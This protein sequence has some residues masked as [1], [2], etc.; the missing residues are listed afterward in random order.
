MSKIQTIIRSLRNG[1]RLVRPLAAA[2]VPDVVRPMRLYSSQ[3][4]KAPDSIP[5]IETRAP[6][7]SSE[8]EKEDQQ[9]E[10]DVKARIL[11]KAL[12]FVGA[13]GWSVEALGAGAEAAGYPGVSHGLFPNGGADLVHYFN[14]KCNEDLVS[15]MKSWPKEDLTESKVPTKFVENAIVTR[16]QMLEPY[17]AS[18]PKAM[19]I[20]A[21]PSNV[22]NCLATLLSLVDDICYHSG[23]RSVDFNWYIRR[24]GLAGIYKAAELFYLTDSS[25]GN[26]GTRAFVAAR[27]RDAQLIQTAMNM[28][29]VSVAP[30]TLTAA[31]VT[32]KN[33]LGINT[34]K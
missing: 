34:L 3:G 12:G 20:Q 31:F 33:I 32:A 18:W 14:V 28:N 15:Q 11:E 1:H 24:V 2:S 25:A 6:G 29:P 10:E 16:L 19:A 27:I 7:A 17:K 21:L 30:Q 4:G 5:S 26:S 9:Y 22:P 8:S 23:D 13:S